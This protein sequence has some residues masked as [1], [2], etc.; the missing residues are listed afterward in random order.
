MWAHTISSLKEG[1]CVRNDLVVRWMVRSFDPDDMIDHL[2]VV[3]MD[4]LH[5]FKL[6]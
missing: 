3:P 1:P 4:M 5:H 2:W 6:G